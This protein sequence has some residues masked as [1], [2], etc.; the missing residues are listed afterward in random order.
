MRNAPTTRPPDIPPAQP[1]QYGGYVIGL[2]S[3]P[4]AD[5]AL[6]FLFVFHKLKPE[7][8]RSY[9]ADMLYICRTYVFCIRVSLLW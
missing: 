8:C 6:L 5:E 9:D 7:L 3:G 1:A 2:F 4:G